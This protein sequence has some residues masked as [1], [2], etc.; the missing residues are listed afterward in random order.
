MDT[1]SWAREG[2]AVTGIDF[3]AP[4]IETARALAAEL[5]V[6]ASFILSDLYA[7]PDNLDGRFDIVYTSYGAIN[8]L[9]DLD[10]WAQVAAHFVKPGGAFY[11]AEFH[12]VSMI[13]DDDPGVTELRV[14]FPYFPR[15]EPLRWEGYG[16]YTDRSAK[17]KND[18]TY[19]WP[20]PT[21]EVIS[22][23]INAGLRIDHFHEFADTSYRILPFMEPVD[24][25][26]YRLPTCDGSVPFVYSVKATRPA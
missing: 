20:H 17:L 9:P 19:E 3:S 24:G 25:R 23:L 12:P 4:A 5:G 26:M 13:F 2:A 7:L 15:S 11:V 18:V 1:I 14:R 16:D 22:A 21:S 10:R 8:W 6:Q